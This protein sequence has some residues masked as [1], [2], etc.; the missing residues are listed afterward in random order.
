ML[1]L[2]R[3]AMSLPEDGRLEYRLIG[4]DSLADSVGW[5]KFS[6]EGS[7]LPDNESF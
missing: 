7:L 2:F 3:Q 6:R 1:D 5:L 4:R